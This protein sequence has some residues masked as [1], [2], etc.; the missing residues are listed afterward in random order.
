MKSSMSGGR[1]VGF[2]DADEVAAED[3]YN[4]GLFIAAPE[5]FLC[6]ERVGRHIVELLRRRLDAIEVRAEAYVV[7]ADHPDD[8]VDMIY[9]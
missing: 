6:Y 2:E 7:G 8:V 5:E 3:L 9:Q 1:F 4:I